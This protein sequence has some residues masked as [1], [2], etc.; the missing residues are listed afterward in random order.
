[1][2]Q[3]PD[4]ANGDMLQV[5]TEAGLDLTQPTALDFYLIF[6]RQDKAE[7]AE[8]ALVTQY[9][10]EP[11]SLY[12]NPANQWEIKITLTMLPSYDAISQQEKEFDAFARK[13]AGHHDGW[14]VMEP[15]PAP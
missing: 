13:F 12:C 3:F 1:M 9:P 14:G 5:L 11:V 6:K 2:M 10:H 4:D 7:R 8:Q 15:E